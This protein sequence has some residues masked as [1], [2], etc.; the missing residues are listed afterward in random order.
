MRLAG[1]TAA[2]DWLLDVM[3]RGAPAADLRRWLFA[4]VFQPPAGTRPRGRIICNCADVSE[5]EIRADLAAGLDL[6]AIQAMRKCGTTCGS[7]LPEL[8]RLSAP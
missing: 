3:A 2:R 1:E 7:C 4:P 8:K 5:A 6:A